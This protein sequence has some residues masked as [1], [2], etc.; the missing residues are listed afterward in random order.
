M[1][2]MLQYV[3]KGQDFVTHASRPDGKNIK[4]ETSV[5]KCVLCSQEQHVQEHDYRFVEVCIKNVSLLKHLFDH[6]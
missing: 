4:G 1:F 2:Q 3:V 6:K 5:I